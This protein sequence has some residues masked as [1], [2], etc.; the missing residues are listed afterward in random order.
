MKTLLA[1]C[2]LLGFC[3]ACAEPVMTA[4]AETPQCVTGQ[5]MVARVV[6]GVPDAYEFAN[7]TG[8]R[9]RRFIHAFDQVPPVTETDADGVTIIRADSQSQLLVIFTRSGCVVGIEPMPLAAVEAFMAG[10]M[11]GRPAAH[12]GRRV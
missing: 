5:A 6:Q 11:P 1:L 4:A 7:L 10:Q 3:Q 8:E 2:L 12:L 9:A